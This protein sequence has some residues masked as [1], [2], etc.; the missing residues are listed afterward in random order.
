MWQKKK[1]ISLAALWHWRLVSEVAV[2][3]IFCCSDSSFSAYLIYSSWWSW[4]ISQALL[5]ERLMPAVTAAAVPVCL[6]TPFHQCDC[7][8]CLMMKND[9]FCPCPWHSSIPFPQLLNGY[10]IYIIYSHNL[11]I[12]VG[13][14][15]GAHKNWITP[16]TSSIVPSLSMVAIFRMMLPQVETSAM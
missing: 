13:S 14:V 6:P 15:F 8:I 16:R 11:W 5:C 3:S 4:R 12:S 10:N 2:L 7:K 9:Y 1:K